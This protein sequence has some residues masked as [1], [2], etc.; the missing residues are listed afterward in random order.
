[1]TDHPCHYCGVQMW[2]DK[3]PKH[4]D[5]GMRETKDHVIPRC[6]GGR[7]AENYVKA[8]ARCNNAKKDGDYDDFMLFARAMLRGKRRFSHG[9]AALMFN[10]WQT[11]RLF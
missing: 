8:C 1:M 7:G 4:A 6:R 3:R 2:R 11:A 5:G 10:A 9:Q